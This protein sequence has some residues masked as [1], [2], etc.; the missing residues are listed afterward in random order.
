MCINWKVVGGLAA[1]GVGIFVV[2]PQYVTAALPLL[3]LAACPLS[4]IIMM[5]MM[6]GDS[7]N[8]A[9]ATKGQTSSDAVDSSNDA[10]VSALRAKVDQLEAERRG[11]AHLGDK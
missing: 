9:C 1:V 6:S 2:A 3:L 4:M 10:E 11:T 7:K 8:K 5:K